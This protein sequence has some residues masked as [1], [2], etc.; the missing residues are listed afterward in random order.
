MHR[1][2][3]KDALHFLWDMILLTFHIRQSASTLPGSPEE[4]MR[5]ALSDALGNLALMQSVRE[6]GSGLDTVEEHYVPLI[7]S[8]ED[9]LDHYTIFEA[10]NSCPSGPKAG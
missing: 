2:A 1:I 9:H 7:K 8:H 4:M 6:G 5:A 3:R 10:S